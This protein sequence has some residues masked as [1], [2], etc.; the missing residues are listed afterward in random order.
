MEDDDLDDVEDD[1]LEDIE[2]N[3]DKVESDDPR[4]DDDDEEHGPQSTDA[5]VGYIVSHQ[6]PLGL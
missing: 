6:A 5:T 3:D 2:D 4:E 1:D